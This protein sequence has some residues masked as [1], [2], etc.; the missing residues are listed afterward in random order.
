MQEPVFQPMQ[1][2][3][4]AATGIGLKATAPDITPTGS[5]SLFCKAPTYTSQECQSTGQFEQAPYS[6]AAASSVGFSSPGYG[7][8]DTDYRDL[9]Q[10]DIS[11][12]EFSG[13]EDS[14]VEE[15]EVSSDVIDKQDQ[16]EDMTYHETFREVRSF[17]GWNHIPVHESDLSEPDMS[18]N[19][20]KGKNPQ[21]PVRISV[22]MPPDDWLGQKN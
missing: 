5:A 22:A 7:M 20:W 10:Q 4:A 11:E 17:M 6:P 12:T 9:P 15:G 14:A 21:K 13:D 16:T 19:P 3:S 2:S 18:N 8:S 1:T